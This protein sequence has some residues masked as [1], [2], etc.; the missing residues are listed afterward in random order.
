MEHNKITLYAEI[1][2]IQVLESQLTITHAPDPV[3]TLIDDQPVLKLGSLDQG[4]QQISWVITDAD[5]EMTSN[6]CYFCQSLILQRMKLP[7]SATPGDQ[8]ILIGAESTL[9]RIEQR[10]NQSV[11][12]GDLATEVGVAGRIDSLSPGAVLNL[13]YI[14]NN[15]WV[16]K[17]SSGNFDVAVNRTN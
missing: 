10:D 1:S 14:G 2:H 13:S 3:I 9:F 11:L 4:S 5:T 12:F 16:V 6:C 8:L 7:D 17:F 15:R